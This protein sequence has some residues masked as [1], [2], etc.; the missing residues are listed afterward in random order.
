MAAR[1]M[2]RRLGRGRADSALWKVIIV[3]LLVLL[4]SSV[5]MAR[6]DWCS[7]DPVLSFARN[8]LPVEHVLDV[9]VWVKHGGVALNDTLA[10]L[11]VLIPSNV[12]GADL[13]APVTEPAFQ[14]ETVFKP[15]LEP[16]ASSN[17]R[18]RLDAFVPATDG[19]YPAE[20]IMTKLVGGLAIEAPVR[21]TGQTGKSIR[22]W[23]EFSP[24]RVA[25]QHVA[26]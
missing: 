25:C 18:V 5:A 19:A 26:T 22:A 14:I 9:Q 3:I 23:I 11:T 8:P 13:L 1:D 4:T 16:T 15:S 21:C 6:Y 7:R 20:I 24:F 10:T 2:L 17:Y 12:S